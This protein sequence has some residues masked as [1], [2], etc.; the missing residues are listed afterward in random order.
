MGGFRRALAVVVPAVLLTA[1]AVVG[2][3]RGEWLLGALVLVA[4][5]LATALT[6]RLTGEGSDAE[7]RAAERA[8][9]LALVALPGVL[10]VYLGFRAG[11][12]EA[13]TVAVLAVALAAACVARV[14]LGHR[15]F[16][17]MGWAA[18]LAGVPLTF[19][20]GWTL[21]SATWS[22]S[23]ERALVE[24]DRALLYLLVLLLF[25]S[26]PWTS[27]RLRWMVRLLALGMV[28]VCAASLVTRLLPNLWEVSPG[29]SP[30]LNWPVT[31]FNALGLLAAFAIVLCLHLTSDE[32]EPAAV[33]A[34][35][36]APASL[37]G[38][39]LLL[40]LSRGA[41]GAL[42]VGIPAYLLLARPRGILGGAI[43]TLPLAALATY[44]TYGA[45]LLFSPDPTSP[46]AAA[47]GATV[48]VTVAACAL[49]AL[50]LRVL[51]L[52][53]DG[54]L[55]RMRLPDRARRPVVATA[56]VGLVVVLL[57]LGAALDAPGTLARQYERF[58]RSDPVVAADPRDRLADPGNNFRLAP[59]GVA[60]E[61][62]EEHPTQGTGAG[63]FEL[64]WARERPIHFSMIDAHS[65]Y[66]E[67]LAELGPPGIVALA[68][69]L[70]TMLGAL[71]VRA[72]GPDRALWAALLA[73]GLMWA[74][75]GGI[76]W[77]W[78][79]PVVGVW[80]FAAAGAALAR[81]RRHEPRRG[82]R[83]RVLR[84][85]TAAVLVVVAVIPALVA[86]SQD[87]LEESVEEI[88]EGDCAEA[89]AEA[90][91]SLDVLSVRARPYEVIGYC[92]ARQGLG[93]LAVP[94]MQRA[95]ERDPRNWEY[96]YGLAVARAGAGID[97]RAAART[98]LRLNRFHVLA[99]DGW[100]RFGRGGDPQS[101]RAAA[102]GARL[103]EDLRR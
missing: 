88:A 39:V 83:S 67:V 96:H 23:T 15:P 37:L 100:R 86:L 103:P 40:T 29:I 72:R 36:A 21:A 59:W 30:R 46:G 57:S 95:V 38:P 16:Q 35:A 92:A 33:R 94:A 89:V 27:R 8:G 11:G 41:I 42:M 5:A 12:F 64:V 91:A 56:V 61:A 77:D 7:R 81:G 13:T 79:M 78:E 34:L 48:A 4:A 84:W 69:A 6:V 43:A 71:A 90:R 73:A 53:L 63:T 47:Q 44:A 97:P 25:A 52:P 22:G 24:F 19:F 74:V 82:E 65:L 28:A 93:A 18:A 31:Y 98:A 50:A 99:R 2:F 70:A 87:R 14:L 75:R 20:A 76:D 101:W 1:G 85:S 3:V 10:T 60:V 68:L 51:F 66:L 32:T 102:S 55:A 26:V 62:F 54:Y 17:G 45:E 80:L 9:V 58:L 49:G